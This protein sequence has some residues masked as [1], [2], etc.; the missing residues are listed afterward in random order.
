LRVGDTG[1][2]PG[3]RPIGKKL[4]DKGR[5]IKMD[6]DRAQA[7]D[8]KILMPNGRIGAWED[9]EPGISMKVTLCAL[10]ASV[11]RRD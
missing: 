7:R 11:L 5:L 3:F 2:G 6:I 8:G 1:R 10:L 4:I 9:F